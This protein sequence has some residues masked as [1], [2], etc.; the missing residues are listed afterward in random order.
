MIIDDSGPTFITFFGSSPRTVLPQGRLPQEWHGTESDSETIRS[1]YIHP[2]DG[3]QQ[4]NS[5][6][7]SIALNK[8]STFITTYCLPLASV[9]SFYVGAVEMQLLLTISFFQF[10]SSALTLINPPASNCITEYGPLA[11]KV[12]PTF[13][14]TVTVI[15]TL[16]TTDK[17]TAPTANVA[18]QVLE[19]SRRRTLGK[20]ATQPVIEISERVHE[21]VFLPT[22]SSSSSSMMQ[23]ITRVLRRMSAFFGSTVQYNALLNQD[24]LRH[25]EHATEHEAHTAT[26]PI[27]VVCTRTIFF[28]PL[29]PIINPTHNSERAKAYA[30]HFPQDLPTAPFSEAK[31]ERI[32]TGARTEV[33]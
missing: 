19:V 33:K 15:S 17:L 13:T 10:I 24:G 14:E 11:P 29:T 6:F 25:R 20:V 21:S 31:Y 8:Y 4:V 5:T 27:S 32:E 23:R 9:P 22:S 1:C 28:I 26:Y 18:K 16:K 2:A 12:V 3:T 30:E 7:P